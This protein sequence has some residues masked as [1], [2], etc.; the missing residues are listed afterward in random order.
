M[1]S[2][3]ACCHGA[4][5]CAYAARDFR[6]HQ[7]TKAELAIIE[8]S[9]LKFCSDFVEDLWIEITYPK[10]LNIDVG[11]N[12]FWGCE[13]SFPGFLQICPKNDYA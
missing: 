7:Y 10:F 9:Q 6:S 3:V 11:A 5:L 13:G 8:C 1:I 2:I 4:K 12:N